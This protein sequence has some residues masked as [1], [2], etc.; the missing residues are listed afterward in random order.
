M[1]CFYNVSPLYRRIVIN[2]IPAK[3][4]NSQIFVIENSVH[5]LAFSEN[6]FIFTKMNMK[7]KDVYIVYCF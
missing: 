4:V 2:R 5:V 6:K 1:L 7:G 3:I